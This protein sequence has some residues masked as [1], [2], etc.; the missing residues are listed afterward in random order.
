MRSG[1]ITKDTYEKE[2]FLIPQGRDFV[3]KAQSY[4]APITPAVTE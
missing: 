4:M 2:E 1:I 3:E